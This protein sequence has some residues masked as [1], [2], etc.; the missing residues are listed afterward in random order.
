MA[1]IDS[2]DTDAL[3]AATPILRGQLHHLQPALARQMNTPSLLLKPFGAALRTHDTQQILVSAI[4]RST[5]KQL[6]DTHVDNPTLGPSSSPKQQKKHRCP[7]PTILQR[8]PR[9]GRQ[10]LS[11]LIRATTHAC[12]PSE[13]HQRLTNVPKRPCSQSSLLLPHRCPSAPLHWHARVGAASISATPRSPDAWPTWSLHTW[14]PR[15]TVSRPSQVYHGSPSLVLNPKEHAWTSCSTCMDIRTQ[16]SSR[17]SAPAQATWPNLNGRKSS[18]GKPASTWLG[19]TKVHQTPV[20]R[21]GPPTNSHPGCLGRHPDH[22]AQT[23]TPNNS[24]EATPRDSRLLF[25]TTPHTFFHGRH[26]PQQS[27]SSSGAR[28]PL[29]YFHGTPPPVAA[30][31]TR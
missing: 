5:H 9:S 11:G 29:L 7:P 15:Y 28:S 20:Q 12:T 13:P 24:S 10:M 16:D 1:A 17:Q 4:Q 18:T 3:Y 21:H 2:P 6:M 27:T 23:T 22:P 30:V 25:F 26:Y 31:N 8:S 19:C 14:A